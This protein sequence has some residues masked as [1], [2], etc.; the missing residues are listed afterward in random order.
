MGNWSDA[1][2]PVQ[3]K[4]GGVLDPAAPTWACPLCPVHPFEERPSAPLPRRPIWGCPQSPHCQNSDSD[5]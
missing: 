2:I 4:G 5:K 1:C 3:G